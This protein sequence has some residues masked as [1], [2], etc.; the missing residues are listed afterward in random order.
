MKLLNYIFTMMIASLLLSGCDLNESPKF[1]DGDAFV[2]FSGSSLDVAENK[3]TLSIP[4]TLSSLGG[5]SSVVTYTVKDGTAKEG[6][7]FNV[8]GTGTLSFTKEN[9]VQNIEIEVIN[10]DAYTGDLVF[11][12]EL[13]NAGNV[14]MGSISK[15]EVT[16]LDKDH[17]LSFILG[18][19]AA[20]GESNFGGGLAWDVSIAKDAD[21]IT[22]VWITN[23]VPGGSDAKNPVYGVVNE[24]KT[25][26]IIPIKQTLMEYASYDAVLLEGYYGGDESRIPSGGKLTVDIAADGTLTFQDIFG[27]LVYDDLSSNKTAGWFELVLAGAKMTKK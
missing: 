27:A 9:P 3:G 11:T 4:V 25:Q 22:K 17:P 24:E 5:L 15:C 10:N 14:N 18:T 8:N 21:D 7:N 26:L 2:G 19:F 1:S 13:A 23:L 16:I 12:I 20:V 6:T